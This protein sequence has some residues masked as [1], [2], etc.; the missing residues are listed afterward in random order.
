VTIGEPATSSILG[1]I[2]PAFYEQF[3]HTK[4]FCA[5]FLYL[6][7]GFVIFWQKNID[8]KAAHKILATLTTGVNFINILHAT[9]KHL[10]H[11]CQTGGLQAQ[12]GPFAW[13]AQIE[14]ESGTAIQIFIF[15]LLL[16]N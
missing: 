14:I 16:F 8:P 5:A 9:L 13:L 11:A 3:F 10:K 15:Y 4:V 12:C 1:S 7:F 2:S 6:K